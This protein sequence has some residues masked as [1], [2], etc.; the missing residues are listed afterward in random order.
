MGDI[1]GP[2]HF[3][4]WE[5]VLHLHLIAGAGDLPGGPSA[6]LPCGYLGDL[7]LPHQG[8]GALPICIEV[9]KLV[10]QHPPFGSS[11]LAILQPLSP[12]FGGVDDVEGILTSDYPMSTRAHF[13]KNAPLTSPTFM[14][15]QPAERVGNGNGTRFLFFCSSSS[16]SSLSLSQSLSRS[17]SL[18]ITSKV[19]LCVLPT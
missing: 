5:V 15:S 17:K 13:T 4:Y 3:Q 18:L 10:C 9:S 8:R 19:W 11:L 1:L 2:R 14:K 16:S 7:T 12:K 6:P